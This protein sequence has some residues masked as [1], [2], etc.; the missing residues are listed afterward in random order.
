MMDNLAQLFASAG[1]CGSLRVTELGG[2][3]SIALN[4]DEAVVAASVIKVL[5]ALEVESQ[6]AAGVLDPRER[7][8]LAVD[9]RTPGPTGFSLFT[10]DVDVA[11]GDLVVAMLSIS[12][13]AA[14]DALLA[15]VGIDAVNAT[16]NR[17]HLTQTFVEASLSE[18]IATIAMDAGFSEYDA[19]TTWFDAKPPAAE[20]ELVDDKIRVSRALTASTANRTSA[21]DMVRLLQLIWTDEAGPATAC[22]RLRRQ[23]RHQLSGNRIAAAFAPPVRVAA[24][25]GGLMGVV[26]NEIGVIEFPGGETYVAAV[27]TRSLTRATNESDVNS[28]IRDAT[29]W[30]VAQ[31]RVAFAS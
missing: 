26:R 23:M 9:E 24:K 13:N 3:D 31:L 5:I 17:L 29:K 22:A 2:G 16:A 30:A 27:F 21:L 10:H 18:T 4:A 8:L 19:M 25:S 20:S 15:R 28:A 12:D 6:I 14:T 7:Q 11:V 1:C